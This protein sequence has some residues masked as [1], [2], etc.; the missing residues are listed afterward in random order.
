VF[1]Q[2]AANYSSLLG[3]IAPILRRE[4][5]ECIGQPPPSD[6]FT[7]FQLDGLTI[8]CRE[9]PTMEWD[10]DFSCVEGED[11]LFTVFMVG[12]RPTGMVSVMH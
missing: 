7:A 11:Y 12:W 9:S 10:L 2:I 3:S 5:Q 4:Y 8:P 1:Q 6:V